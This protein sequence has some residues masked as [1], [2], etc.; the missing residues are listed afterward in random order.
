MFEG[1]FQNKC[2]RCSQLTFC[3][4]FDAAMREAS[5]VVLECSPL[6]LF[7]SALVPKLQGGTR[8]EE[9]GRSRKQHREQTPR[10]K[11]SAGTSK[12]ECGNA[13]AGGESNAE[14]KEGGGVTHR[15]IQALKRAFRPAGPGDF[16]RK[17]CERSESVCDRAQTQS[18][19]CTSA[20]LASLVRA[21]RRLHSCWSLAESFAERTKA[22]SRP[23]ATTECALNAYMPSYVPTLIHCRIVVTLTRQPRHAHASLLAVSKH[24]ILA[25][26]TLF[27][28]NA[29]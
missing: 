12:V 21:L 18:A 9:H 1:I 7:R 14:R 13:I 23:C 27:A 15:L 29:A 24:A 2:P 19:G 26:R 28:F 22:I 4:S 10:K 5:G 11:R 6:G 16:E 20:I 17:P 25:F 8:N 3:I